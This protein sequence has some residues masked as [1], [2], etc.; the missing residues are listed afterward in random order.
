MGICED[1]HRLYGCNY[2]SA[3][4]QLDGQV[5]NSLW[6]KFNRPVLGD[7]VCITVAVDQIADIL[8]KGVSTFRFSFIA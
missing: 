5:E 3:G 6:S 8:M 2:R 4:H 1:L 7:D